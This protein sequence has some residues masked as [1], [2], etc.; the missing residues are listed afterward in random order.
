MSSAPENKPAY[1]ILHHTG[2][3]HPSNQLDLTNRY[4]RGKEFPHSRRGFNV[5]YHYFLERSGHGIQCRD[6]D[7]E[8]AH[9]KGWNFSSIAIAL[10][11]NFDIEDPTEAQRR[12][13]ALLIRDIKT[14]HRIPIQN[15]LEHRDVAQTSCPGSRLY[16]RWAA[17]TYLK[18]ELGLIAKLIE[19][20]KLAFSRK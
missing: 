1:V 16:K 9:T 13:L 18:Y 8:G 5:G 12:A 20:L 6:E 11:G 17:L 7:E 10:A 15:I 3:D 4:H 2:N 14:R 19:W